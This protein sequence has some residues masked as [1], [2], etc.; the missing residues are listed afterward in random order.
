MRIENFR[1]HP[2]N[3]VVSET[4]NIQDMIAIGQKNNLSGDLIEVNDVSVKTEEIVKKGLFGILK[5]VVHKIIIS[6]GDDTF[7]A[8]RDKNPGNLEKTTVSFMYGQNSPNP[9]LAMVNGVD[10]FDPRDTG[11]FME[12]SARALS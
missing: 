9:R 2:R 12:N 7:T 6:K 3:V 11:S 5:T 4:L 1:E 10:Y 8:I